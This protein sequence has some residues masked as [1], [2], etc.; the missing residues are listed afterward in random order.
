MFLIKS[1]MDCQRINCDSETI[2]FI[3]IGAHA[4]VY[5]CLLGSI[6]LKCEDIR[7]EEN[8]LKIWC[9]KDVVSKAKEDGLNIMIGGDMKAHIW[10]LDKCENKNGKLLKSVMDEI[11]LQILTVYEGCYMAFWE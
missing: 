3:K 11:H 9:V 8:V 4:K 1:D 10:E 6:Y 2:C 7:T 5:E